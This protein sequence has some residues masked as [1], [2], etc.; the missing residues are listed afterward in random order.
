MSITRLLQEAE[1]EIKQ[2]V[3][4][5]NLPPSLLNLGGL[6]RTANLLSSIMRELLNRF[7]AVDVAQS[8]EFIHWLNSHSEQQA[9]ENLLYEIII[10]LT[11]WGKISPPKQRGRHPENA[12]QS[13][14]KAAIVQ[15]LR[16]QSA[17]KEILANFLKDA[18]IIAQANSNAVREVEASPVVKSNML[19][20]QRNVAST[21]AAPYVNLQQESASAQPVHAVRKDFEN[22]PR[23][24]DGFI[25]FCEYCNDLNNFPI[26]DVAEINH[27]FDSFFPQGLSAEDFKKLSAL[28]L[29]LNYSQSLQIE[30]RLSHVSKILKD[31]VNSACSTY[32][33]FQNF[34]EISHQGPK[35]LPRNFQQFSRFN[36]QLDLCY[37]NQRTPFKIVKANAINNIQMLIDY[38]QWIKRQ[39]V[40][41][42][43][44]KLVGFRGVE[45]F[46][47]FPLEEFENLS[48]DDLAFVR[49]WVR[50][51]A[52]PEAIYD[53][54]ERK[55]PDLYN[56]WFEGDRFLDQITHRLVQSG[57]KPPVITV[58]DF[59]R[60][61]QLG[62]E[63]QYLST[64][65][66]KKISLAI[67]PAVYAQW[68]GYMLKDPNV[69]DFT[70][71]DFDTQ[72][73]NASRSCALIKYCTGRISEVRTT[74]LPFAEYIKAYQEIKNIIEII[75]ALHIDFESQNIQD[76]VDVKEYLAAPIDITVYLTQFA[77]TVDGLARFSDVISGNFKIKESSVSDIINYFFPG[78]YND[79][80][81]NRM[82]L[83]SLTALQLR[84]KQSKPSNTMKT[85]FDDCL[86]L[87]QDY[88][89]A[90]KAIDET[91]FTNVS[92]LD[93]LI[94]VNKDKWYSLGEKLSKYN[95]FQLLERRLAQK[96]IALIK[97]LK[98]LQS[99]FADTEVLNDYLRFNQRMQTFPV[100]NFLVKSVEQIGI[101]E[102]VKAY[103][104]EVSLQAIVQQSFN[105]EITAISMVRGEDFRL[106]FKKLKDYYTA[107]DRLMPGMVLPFIENYVQAAFSILREEINS[108]QPI[109][110]LNEVLDYHIQE[111]NIIRN[112]GGI[113]P[114]LHKALMNHALN[115]QHY[116]YAMFHLK[117][118]YILEMEDLIKLINIDN[119]WQLSKRV[120]EPLPI[121][122]TKVRI[123]QIF[124]H[125]NHEYSVDQNATSIFTKPINQLHDICSQLQAFIKAINPR[126]AAIDAEFHKT[127][128]DFVTEHEEKFKNIEDFTIIK[129]F[130][131]DIPVQQIVAQDQISLAASSGSMWRSSGD[132]PVAGSSG[133]S[134]TPR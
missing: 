36:Q 80:D 122:I 3:D 77:P 112:I 83:P 78:R 102:K 108:R 84:V 121:K 81:L 69:L 132:K 23:N 113:S 56:T 97:Y 47:K 19:D 12:D 118:G 49:F 117:H 30:Q 99:P 40:R 53:I 52:V 59:F 71:N 105:E 107:M 28:N 60:F 33:T 9:I 130:I 88:H 131:D 21:S 85:I 103:I 27:F 134:S 65:G 109:A 57:Q 5:F 2:V 58:E 104:P 111:L 67:T 10:S 68:S 92:M 66:A 87:Y 34:A 14:S 29:R 20:R 18:T 1:A 101:L 98:W 35:V 82:V 75:S 116:K 15:A 54:F 74:I 125:S 79:E 120:Q 95:I 93:N 46:T 127:I 70:K 55:Y 25:Q 96:R 114:D 90:I 115:F 45:L 24:I 51:G 11:A 63:K 64:Y 22:F 128:C 124:Y 72:L 42:M 123:N 76:Y 133:N 50:E 16:E 100:Q 91:V 110:K 4:S 8:N 86:K 39:S 37:E 31:A 119:E 126:P 13:I 94:T 106:K 43:A 7:S 48:E 32:H 41:G 61:R 73:G 38:C 44:P 62:G 129:K 17:A 89:E 6:L 26:T